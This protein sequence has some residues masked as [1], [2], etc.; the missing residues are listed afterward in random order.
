[1]KKFY[2]LLATVAMTATMVAQGTF[3]TPVFSE[4]F[5]TLTDA[6][7]LSTSNTNFSYV[8]VGTSTTANSWTN[9]IVAKEPSSFTGS[10]MILGAKG[11][12]VSTTDKTGMT[13][14]NK[15]AYTFK[16]KTA[17]SL[18]SSVLVSAVGTGASFGS[19][20]GFTGSQLA[21]ALQVNGTNLQ[22]R[23]GGAWT[24]IQTV[25]VN[26][27]YTV[28]VVF[29]NS[30]SDLT[31]GAGETLVNN[32]VHVYVDGEKKGEYNAAT[33]SLAVA[34]FRIYATTGEFEVDDIA[35]YDTLPT[36][37][38]PA[39]SA[40]PAAIT[41]TKPATAS[42]SVTATGDNL[43]YVWQKSTNNG[44][45]WND[46]AE[47]DGSD[48]NTASYTTPSTTE[49]MDGY[50]YRV[51]VSSGTCTTTSA[52][53]KLTVE[54]TLSAGD[55]NTA[56]AALVKNTVVENNI[57]FGAKAEVQI[58]NMNGQVVK[59]A[60]V[61]ENTSVDVSSLAKGTYIV[62]GNVNGKAVSQKIIKK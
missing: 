62:T 36:C 58:I 21:A 54:T 27:S 4:D 51:I 43:K 40:E 44:T 42:F 32:K 10:S 15:G 59:S 23:A 3:G 18:T 31:Y 60:F 37:T 26:T 41:V 14:F 49:A 2:S 47:A 7:A 34:A 11:G 12:S 17:S 24:T 48:M 9:K 22:V 61:N 29:N 5:G 1:M 57:L 56:K 39:I 28:T 45:D 6:T 53:A 13:S 38:A 20:S 25:A 35:V 8:R 33:N 16:F 55:I 52:A 19:T 46:I 50:L 30:G